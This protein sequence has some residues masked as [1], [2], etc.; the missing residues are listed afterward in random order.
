MGTGRGAG[1]AQR[2]RAGQRRR[3]VA[4]AVKNTPP[5]FDQFW[6]N[7]QARFRQ[8]LGDG[9]KPGRPLALGAA[10]VLALWLLSGVYM[11]DTSEQGVELIFGQLHETTGPGLHYNFP[12]PIGQVYT[13]EVTTVNKEEIGFRSTGSDRGSMQDV[14]EES[15][16]LTGDKNLVK[17]HYEV[18][19]QVGD[20]ARYLFA[21]MNP[22]T[23]VKPVAE[24]A[25]RE[26]VGN[27]P[28][29]RVISN[30]KERIAQDT[31]QLMQRVLDSY[32]T[33]IQVD[34]VV[35][36]EADAP[37]QVLDAFID[38]L[39]AQQEFDTSQEKARRYAQ[40]IIPVAEGQAQKMILDAQAYQQEVVN[41]AKGDT[42]RFLAIY[43]QYKLAK[44]VTRKRMLL[45]TLEEV[46]GGMQKTIVDGKSGAVP[47]LPIPAL[48]ARQKESAQ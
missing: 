40:G 2:R 6:Q 3:G 28:I 43:E 35:M 25:M 23:T 31:R 11:V 46:L 5:D 27:T 42:A 37:T 39:S 33:G 44:D 7:A 36:L 16:M 17:I 14:P 47:Y 15:I 8:V 22:D 20:P 34:R 1:R 41:R 19:W 10:A 21:V 12:A 30:E 9:D 24:S 26:V 45:E 38:V 29:D 18:Q 13:P 4:G 32:H 48:N